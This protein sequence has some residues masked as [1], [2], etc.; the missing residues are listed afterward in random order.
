MTGETFRQMKLIFVMQNGAFKPQ[1]SPCPK[2]GF[3]K[4]TQK[5]VEKHS[6]APPSRQ[7][8]CQKIKNIPPQFPFTHPSSNGKVFR[9][10][11]I[12]LL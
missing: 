5:K 8:T 10:F 6:I 3:F 1:G 11:L 2:S 7:E 9:K 4:H 12:I